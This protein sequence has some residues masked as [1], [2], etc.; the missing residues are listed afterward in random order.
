MRARFYEAC[1]LMEAHSESSA[2]CGR[3]QAL[4]SSALTQVEPE[5]NQTFGLVD[6]A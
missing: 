3:A 1:S 5:I 2:R 4:L 6:S